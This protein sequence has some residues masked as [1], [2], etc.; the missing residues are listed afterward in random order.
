MSCFPQ[1]D[2]HELNF[3]KIAKFWLKSSICYRKLYIF[4]ELEIRAFNHTSG[5]DLVGP[6]SLCNQSFWLRFY[7]AFTLFFGF[8]CECRGVFHRTESDL[9]LFLFD[10]RKVFLILK[11][12]FKMLENDFLILENTAIFWLKQ[13]LAICYL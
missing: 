9:F 1:I 11:H 4:I 3:S 7:V 6:Q 2:A 12:L 5:V 8:F 13:W 10:T